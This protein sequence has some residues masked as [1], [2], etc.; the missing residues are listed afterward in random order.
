MDL[1]CSFPLPSLRLTQL[2]IGLHTLSS[3]F[4][5]VYLPVQVP[6]DSFKKCAVGISEH[7]MHSLKLV[8]LSLI[9]FCCAT[10]DI[11]DQGK[12]IVIC[13][14]RDVAYSW[15]QIQYRWPNK[16]SPEQLGQHMRT[17]LAEMGLY[18]PSCLFWYKAECTP[19]SPMY[20]R[21]VGGLPGVIAT[22]YGADEKFDSVEDMASATNFEVLDVLHGLNRLPF[23]ILS[24][25]YVHDSVIERILKL[26]EASE[27]GGLRISS[28]DLSSDELDDV[29]LQPPSNMHKLFNTTLNS[30]TGQAAAINNSYEFR[31]HPVPPV[32]VKETTM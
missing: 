15:Q 23:N 31:G 30:S 16:Q 14:I 18:R 2:H 19:S 8:Y 10:G 3:F 20:V 6:F 7:F 32:Q 17:A 26:N 29:F 12:N 21:S 24:I 13:G 1:R 27:G 11:I 9:Y 28:I 5:T 4:L 25:D 22:K